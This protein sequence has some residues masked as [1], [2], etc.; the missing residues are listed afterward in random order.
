MLLLQ[1]IYIIITIKH[2]KDVFKLPQKW[3]ELFDTEIAKFSVKLKGNIFTRNVE[4]YIFEVIV[5]QSIARC[6]EALSSV[7]FLEPRPPFKFPADSREFVR[8]YWAFPAAEPRKRWIKMHNKRVR[9]IKPEQTST[10]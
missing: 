3:F 1:L 2:A 8:I 5:S 9:L 6:I 4:K 10:G 7:F